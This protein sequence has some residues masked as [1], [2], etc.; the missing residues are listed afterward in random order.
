MEDWQDRKPSI[1]FVCD[2][3]ESTYER[4]KARGV[5]FPKPP[6]KMPWGTFVKFVD[7][8]ENEFVLKG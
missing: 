5:S 2:D 7:P 8:D 4:M 6:E 3:I 1:V